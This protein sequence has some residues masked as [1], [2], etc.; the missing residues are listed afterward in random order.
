MLLTGCMSPVCC[1][2]PNY[3]QDNPPT[4]NNNQAIEMAADQFG[5]N[6]AKHILNHPELADDIDCKT[7][8]F[9]IA[10]LINDA[11]L[12]GVAN[13]NEK[14]K[15]K[16]K[17]LCTLT[18]TEYEPVYMTKVTFFIKD[19]QGNI[20]VFNNSVDSGNSSFSHF[21]FSEYGKYMYIVFTDEGHPFFVFF[22][23]LK[24]INNDKDDQ[25]GE[26]FEEYY[27]DHIENFYDNGDIVFALMEGIVEG[28]LDG[29]VEIEPNNDNEEEV[30][31]CLFHHNIFNQYNSLSS[32]EP[33]TP[34]K[35]ERRIKMPY[36]CNAFH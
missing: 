30:K 31:R 24:F 11:K 9:K 19:E 33:Y 22:D 21:N 29:E 5:Q 23:T 2:D 20:Q 4:T 15:I 16:Q 32:R 25:V 1:I 7:F 8:P 28:C 10:Q 17:Q 12:N 13:Q 6:L 36:V 14:N 34:S 26:V 18:V 27:L 3:Q 35:S